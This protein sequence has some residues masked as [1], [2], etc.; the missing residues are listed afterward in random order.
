MS[1]FQI[2]AYKWMQHEILRPRQL[3]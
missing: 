1:K 2:R 3:S